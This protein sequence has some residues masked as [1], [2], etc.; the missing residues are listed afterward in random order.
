MFN[1]RMTLS[2]YIQQMGDVQFAAR[3]EVSRWSARAW[4]LG[5][6]I[7]SPQMG[8]HLIARSRGRLRWADLYARP[9]KK[10]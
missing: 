2:R 6:R 4:R 8:A 3:F 10:G 5:H 1:G 9:K 7:P